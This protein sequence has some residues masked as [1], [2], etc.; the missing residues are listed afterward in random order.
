MPLPRISRILHSLVVGS[1]LA[2]TSPLRSAPADFTVESVPAGKTF[3]LSEARGQFV[4]LHFLLKTECPICLRHVR[5]H[6]RRSTNLPG[7]IQ[8]FLKPDTSEEILRWTGRLKTTPEDSIT[9]YRDPDAAL[10]RA[11]EIPDG[12][13]FHGERVHFPALLILNPDGREVFRQVGKDNTD[14]V[15]PAQLAAALKELMKSP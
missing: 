15:S 8:V 1:V 5:E 14:R 6:A 4:V 13:F 3:R 7:V 10:A 9:V 11:Y 12:Y 2:A